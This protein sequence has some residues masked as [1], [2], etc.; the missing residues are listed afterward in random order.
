MEY[1]GDK[2]KD[3]REVTR[4]IVKEVENTIRQYPEQWLW[5]HN[6]WKRTLGEDKPKKSRKA[7]IDSG[8]YLTSAQ[9]LKQMDEEI[10]EKKDDTGA[11]TA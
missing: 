7:R 1:T 2:E 3:I 4:R 10:G 9:L 8:Q 6:R 5:F 11:G